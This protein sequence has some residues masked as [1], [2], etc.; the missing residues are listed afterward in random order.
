MER[1]F[2]YAMLEDK[3]ETILI[4]LGD[5]QAG[6][7]ATNQHLKEINGSVVRLTRESEAAKAYISKDEA[8]KEQRARWS[9]RIGPFVNVLLIGV[10]ILILEH[11]KEMVA[12]VR[13]ALGL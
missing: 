9:A 13:T 6:Q 3:L 2:D 4:R 1:A 11:G 10:V 7:A 12:A 8:E 5:L